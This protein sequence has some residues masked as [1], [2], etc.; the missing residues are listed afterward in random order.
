ME[1][2]EMRLADEPSE[3]IKSGEKT[4]E[5]RLIRL[6][7]E[8]KNRSQKSGRFFIGNV[9]LVLKIGQ[10]TIDKQMFILL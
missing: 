1:Y 3:K 5:I 7:V 6:K 9:C 2:I 8:N 10:L 4:V